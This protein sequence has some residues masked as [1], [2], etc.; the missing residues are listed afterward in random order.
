MPPVKTILLMVLFFTLLFNSC[1]SSAE[2]VLGK[3]H[4]LN[5]YDVVV[6]GADPEGIAAALAASR[7]GAMTLLVDIRSTPGGLFTLGWLNTIDLNTDKR[8]KPLN[9]GIFMEIYRRLDDHSF[10]VSEMEKI[11]RDL[12]EKQ[13]NLHFIA[14]C[15]TVLPLMVTGPMPLYKPGQSLR[16][17]ANLLPENILTKQ[18]PSVLTEEKPATLKGVEIH[19]LNSAPIVVKAAQIIDATQD[20]DLAVA[21]GC[22]FI[23]YGED[24]WRVNRNMATTIVFRLTG[25]SSN[26]W[27]TMCGALQGSKGAGNL[28]GGRRNSVWGFGE[29]MRNFKASSPRLRMRGLN[30][31]R[32][33]DGSVLVN[34]L[35]IFGVDGLC[36]DSR[37]E[38][39]SLAAKEFPALEKF[40][41][42]NIPGMASV[43]IAETAPEMYVRTSRQIKTHYTLTVDDVLENADF[44][45]RIGFGSYPLDIQAQTADHFGDVTGKPEQYAIPFRCIVPIGVTNLT[46]VGRSAGFDSLAQASARTVP[47]G[48]AAAQAAG[49]AAAMCLKDMAEL[50]KCIYESSFIAEL[51]KRLINQG[52]QLHSN[53]A[54]KPAKTKHWAYP[55]LK[56]MRRRGQISGGYTNEYGLDQPISRK[57]FVNRLLN[58]ATE[59]KEADWKWLYESAG[60]IENITLEQACKM[61][62]QVDTLLKNKSDKTN[63]I[64][65][66]A[67]ESAFAE[68]KQRGFF[69]EPWPQQQLI[70]DSTL[71][72]G[73]AYM[74]LIRWA[75][76]PE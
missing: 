59:R 18:R 62:L 11:L 19:F 55:G 71:T 20:A 10:D 70:P 15:T 75:C 2:T 4:I 7:E 33:K 56:F 47:V 16:S 68:F 3:D 25:I 28:L 1:P 64:K 5:R 6:V 27:N 32:Q 36:P 13:K 61:L 45:D 40:L 31:G 63:D 67:K 9:G 50:N 60:T 12:I 76:K 14:G 23:N 54:A 58:L 37:K 43:K 29:T 65:P 53:S 49:I 21:A 44:A 48:I 24:V 26:D 39:R 35:L 22:D 41:Q 30:L 46:V 72:R 42:K 66:A 73:A 38:A 52:V 74:L 8:N 51:Q 69:V 17:D 34:A 57:A